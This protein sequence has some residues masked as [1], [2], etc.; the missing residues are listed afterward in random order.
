MRG[1]EIRSKGNRFGCLQG[2]GFSPRLTP[3]RSGSKVTSPTARC[4]T[5]HHPRNNMG[6]RDLLFS[7]RGHRRARSEDRSEA[8]AFEGPS[9]ANLAVLRPMGSDPS[10]SPI[11][12]PSTSQKRES[13]SM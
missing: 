1:G 7:L 5:Y 8:N 13:N 9:D 12:V 10:T 2:G 4:D 3:A 6:L 11:S